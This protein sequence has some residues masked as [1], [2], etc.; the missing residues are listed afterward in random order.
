MHKLPM[1]RFTLL[2]LGKKGER[3]LAIANTLSLI[4]KNKTIYFFINLKCD[5]MGTEV[6]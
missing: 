2:L 5:K 1:E 4:V 6:R 3:V